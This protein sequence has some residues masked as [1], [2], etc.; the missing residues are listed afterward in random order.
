[1]ATF[2]VQNSHVLLVATCLDSTDIEQ[3]LHHRTSCWTGL[4]FMLCGPKSDA[5]KSDALDHGR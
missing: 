3:F 1:M 5:S 4:P 2:E